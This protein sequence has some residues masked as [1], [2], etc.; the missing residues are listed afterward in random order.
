MSSN[1]INNRK[2]SLFRSIFLNKTVLAT[3]FFTLVALV[4]FHVASTVTLPGIHIKDNGN[5]S[6][7]FTS[8]LNLLAGGGLSRMSFFAVGVGP[9]I[10]AQI[11]VQLLSADLVP[12]LARMAKAGEKGKKQLE[13]ITRF[14][15][16][17]FCIAQSY[18]V[19][20]LLLHNSNGS[21]EIFGKKELNELSA[22]QIIQLMVI[23]TAGS[24]IALFL[25][26]MITKKG[27]GSGITLLILSGILSSIISNFNVAYMTIKSKFDLASTVN[28]VTF[29][30]SILVYFSIFVILL[31]VVIF[32][33]DSTRKIPIQQTGQG[34]ITDI[35]KLPFLPIKLNAAGVIPVI[36]ASSLMTIPTTIAQFLP[37]SNDASWFINDY[38]QIEKPTGLTIYFVLIILFSFFYSYIQLNPKNLAENFEKSGKFIPGVKAGE[39]TEKHITKVLMR[40]NW[41]GAPFLAIVAVLPY[42][43]AM[44]T[45]IPSGVALGGTGIIIIVS[46]S[47]ELWSS[48]KSNSTTSGYNVS[49]SK[50]E[51]KLYESNDDKKDNDKSYQLW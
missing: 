29:V 48:I 1:I 8:M 43:V 21:I 22:K 51:A 7:N 45:T 4:L 16:L 36:F 2:T 35:E 5:V 26:D 50:I 28:I 13:V 12:P 38:L 18:A 33:N 6:N 23:F 15:T 25:G 32:I 39:D 19:I 37:S 3:M 34:L 47:M 41:I 40:I 49:R 24:Y 42:L 31:I 30:L 27:V 17:P 10:T 11:I 44:V 20:A 46:G 14:L 9:Y